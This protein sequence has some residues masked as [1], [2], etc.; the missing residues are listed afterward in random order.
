MELPSFLMRALLIYNE[1]DVGQAAQ[2]GAEGRFVH[3][4][5]DSECLLDS[6]SESLS[7]VGEKGIMKILF[8]AQNIIKFSF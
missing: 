8:Q 1:N 6:G 2:R 7:L 4:E 5:R 3:K